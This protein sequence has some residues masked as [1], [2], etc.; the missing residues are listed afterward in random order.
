MNEER[1]V[2]SIAALTRR[3]HSRLSLGIG[4]DAAAWQ[5]SRSHRSVITTDA[6][7]EGV[8]FSL[9]WMS[10]YD[11][12]WRAMTANASDLAAMGARPVLATVA[13]G[14]PP[15]A[16]GDAVL[17]LYRGLDACARLCGLEI[18]GGD[19]TRS[20]QWIVSITAVG[21]VRLTSLKERTGAR[22]GDVLALT[23]TIGASRAGLLHLAER[24][25]LADPQ[26]AAAVA[27]HRR[28]TPRTAEGRWL[29]ASRHVHAMIDCSDGLSTDLHR[30]LGA[31]HAGA[32]IDAVPIH[33]AAA[34]AAA[35]M[36]ESP[37]EFALAGG[38]D[39]E[40]LVAVAP[41][42]FAHLCARFTG[43]FGQTLRRIGVVRADASLRV[44]KEGNDV[45]LERSGW[46]HFKRQDV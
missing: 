40:L 41:R 1:L 4:D 34:L 29:G 44:V 3:E 35:Q 32:R 25:S 11:V 22:P 36:N 30:L 12:G 27:A 8:H 5:P 24:I 42:A 20:P 13:L 33:P 38:E 2:A 17:E 19:L 45:P 6:L 9:S 26:A 37:M 31:S 15:H 21:E 14:I 39:F 16:D 23:G 28:P 46:D 10:A 43:R 18:A 7:V